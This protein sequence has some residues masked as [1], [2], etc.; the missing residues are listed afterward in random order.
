M[1]YRLISHINGNSN[2]SKDADGYAEY[3]EF[4]IEKV[5]GHVTVMHRNLKS[6][7][8]EIAKSVGFEFENEKNSND[9]NEALINFINGQKIGKIS[10]MSEDEIA[11]NE[12][13]SDADWDWWCHLSDTM[14]YILIHDLPN[15]EEE[16]GIIEFYDEN[17][18]DTEADI[19]DRDTFGILLGEYVTGLYLLDDTFI[20]PVLDNI[21]IPN[22]VYEIDDLNN[23][24][25]SIS[26]RDWS[27]MISEVMFNSI[28]K[29]N[30]LESLDLSYNRINIDELYKLSKLNHL[31]ELYIRRVMD[32]D[33]E[34]VEFNETEF[35]KLKA[36]LPHSEIMM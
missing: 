16:I 8:D 5:S 23:Y 29:F 13:I 35:S 6:I 7:L 36:A 18:F 1:R 31:K 4:L 34:L 24:I 3:D 26:F 9:F 27:R 17:D 19:Y 12:F 30:K 10:Q 25:L 22:N 21:N 20:E 33:D 15:Q 2:F 11:D 14:K 28:V 32:F